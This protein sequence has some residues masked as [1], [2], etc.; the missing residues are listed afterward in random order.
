[1]N[2]GSTN[3]LQGRVILVTGA[4]KRIGRGIALRLAQQGARVAIHYHGSETEARASAAE[5]GNAP[6]F[7]ANLE[8]VAEIESLFLQVEQ[9][10]GRIDGLVNNAARFTRI[11][12][13]EVTEA[14]WD[15]IHSVNLKATFFCCQQ[16][17]RR[18]L[19]GDGGRIVN[20]SSLGGLRPWTYHAHYCASKAGVI[21]LTRA[22]AKAFAPKITVNSVA[23]GVIPFGDPDERVQRLIARTPACRGGTAAEIADAVVFF[24]TTSNFVTG[25]VLAVDGGLSQ[26]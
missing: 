9:R 18:M 2:S 21:M 14:D 1:M 6:I 17:A 22:L 12:P 4:A 23:P 13:L 8:R 16:A 5:C 24:L 15:Y 7:H 19:A 25:Q 3:A 20:I 26:T 10:L 11:N